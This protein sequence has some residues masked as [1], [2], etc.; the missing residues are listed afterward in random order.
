MIAGYPRCQTVLHSSLVSL[1]FLYLVKER[2]LAP[3]TKHVL[4]ITFHVLGRGANLIDW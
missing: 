1:S 4:Q 3:A 2:D